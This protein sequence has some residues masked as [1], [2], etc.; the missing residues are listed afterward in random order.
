MSALS[1]ACERRPFANGTEGEVWM[2]AWCDYCANSDGH[3]CD[4]LLH[5]FVPEDVPWPEAWLPEP[6]DGRFFLPSRMVCLAFTAGPEGD[7]GADER[8]ER[9]VEVTAYWKHRAASCVSEYE[10]S[11][12]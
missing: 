1:E 5:A 2:D 7:P 10:G 6:D 11:D 12:R 4:L 9:V 8:A 3:G